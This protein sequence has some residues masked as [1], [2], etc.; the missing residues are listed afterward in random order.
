M[1]IRRSPALS[2]AL[3]LVALLPAVTGGAQDPLAR[4]KDFY[5]AA[6]YEEALQVLSQLPT[7]G[8][9]TEV[10]AYRVYCL[11]AL[12]RS[13]EA[14]A[15]VESIVRANPMYHP[16]EAEASPRVRQF[17]EKVRRPMLPDVVRQLYA[18]GKDAFFKKDMPTASLAFDRV[19]QLLDDLDASENEEMADLRTLAGGFRELSKVPPPPPP[20]VQAVSLQPSTIASRVPAAPAAL[21]LRIYGPADEDVT[22]PLTVAR[23]VPRWR[24]LNATEERLVLEGTIEVLVSEAGTVLSAAITRSIHPRYDPLLAQAARD[25]TFRPAM[26]N[27]VPVKYRYPVDIRLS[28]AAP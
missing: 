7:R 19:V 17:F 8:Q 1:S 16:T 15:A 3:L 23:V 18:R 27:G 28:T 11:L 2:L 20:P 9:G 13:Q 4:A 21:G 25:W 12:G 10:D 24:P 6:A 5:A 14:T 26:R 22:K